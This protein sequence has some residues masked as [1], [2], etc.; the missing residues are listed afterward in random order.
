MHKL[1]QLCLLRKSLSFDTASILVHAFIVS[2]LDYCNSLLYG[3]S[4]AALHKLQ[5]ISNSAARL[6]FGSHIYDHITAVL[7]DQLHWL[8]IRQCIMYKLA[9]IVH[10]YINGS[11][12]D[13]LRELLILSSY[14]PQYE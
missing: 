3:I 7:H 14:I 9:I 11:L 10:K 6:I 13:Y 8:P 2:K 12:L 1:C 5:F 4:D